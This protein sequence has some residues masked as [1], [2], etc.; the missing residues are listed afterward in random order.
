MSHSWTYADEEYDAIKLTAKDVAVPGEPSVPVIETDLD[1]AEYQETCENG[2][3]LDA[4]AAEILRMDQ[5]IKDLQAVISE[6]GDGVPRA[7]DID[8]DAF[9]ALVPEDRFLAFLEAAGW[10]LEA[11]GWEKRAEELEAEVEAALRG[12]AEISEAGGRAL[13][14]W[15]TEKA[16]LEAENA[17]LKEG[18]AQVVAGFE[19][20]VFVR[21][22]SRDGSPAWAMKL[23]RPLRGLAML[24]ACV[25][26]AKEANPFPGS[27]YDP[28]GNFLEPG[29]EAP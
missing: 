20:G 12:Q 22:I 14:Q 10:A 13:D 29:E 3:L 6:R 8:R 5:R 16:A 19:E 7:S 11:R 27:T 18:A 15:R 9:E 25:P 21:D 2:T 26:G 24:A 4:C 28:N 1:E 17:A 23:V